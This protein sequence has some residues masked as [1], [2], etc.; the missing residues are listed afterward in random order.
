MLLIAYPKWPGATSYFIYCQGILFPIYSFLPVNIGD[1]G[2]LFP[3]LTLIVEM[4]VFAVDFIPNMIFINVIQL[5]ILFV[6]HK[7]TYA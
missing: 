3:S 5:F 7:Y 2:N 6:G 1:V 4:F